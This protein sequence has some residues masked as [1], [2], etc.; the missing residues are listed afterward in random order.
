MATTKTPV[1]TPAVPKQ[2]STALMVAIIVGAVVAVL[3]VVALL[4]S[5]GD[6][7]KPS[8]GSGLTFAPGA[9]ISEFQGVA[10][11]GDPLPRFAGGGA[12]AAVGMPAPGMTGA[13]FDGTPIEI[14]PGDGKPYML[15]F[16]AH[17]CPHCNA[18]VPRLKEWRDQGG[19]P[20]DLRIIGVATGTNQNQPNYPP[21]EWLVDFGWPWEAMADSPRAVAS[22]TYGLDGYPF[23][24]I[25]DGEG[26]V[27][28]RTSGESSV[29][30]IDR[31]VDAAL[32][33]SPALTGDTEPA[34]TEPAST[35]TAAP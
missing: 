11:D 9:Q 24:V 15:V 13:G 5:G 20:S 18:E 31:F 4:V 19:V 32:A 17:W 30:E 14:T 1:K 29:E 25:V 12:D 2:R 7:D 16:L 34:T 21:S 33:S 3:V 22:E 23:M 8:D 35:D 10:V 6:D 26:N 27:A 28:G